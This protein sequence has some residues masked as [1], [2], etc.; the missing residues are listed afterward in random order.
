MDDEIVIEGNE[1]IISQAL[2]KNVEEFRKKLLNYEPPKVDRYGDGFLSQAYLA[3]RYS[4]TG[5]LASIRKELKL[6]S[7]TF[8]YY[9]DTNPD[10]VAAIKIGIYDSRK[11]KISEL[12]GSLFSKAIGMEIEENRVEE[13]GEVDEDGNT[14]V[15]YRKT[16]KTTKQIPPDTQAILTLLQKI[17]PSYNPK[18]VID[19]N[20]N[21]TLNVEE[22]ININVDYR[23]LSTSAI[24]E[25]LESN[26]QPVNNEINKTPDG[27]SV[28]FLGE[29]GEKALQIRNEKRTEYD[30]RK[31]AEKIEAKQR[32]EE[33]KAKQEQS[34]ITVK[35]RIMSEETKRKISEAMKKRYHKEEI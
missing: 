18:Q 6:D 35:K 29:Q 5:S 7:L 8:Q 20:F 30:N 33:E 19:V 2:P 28:R 22:D 27:K 31:K 26:K 12:E 34:G 4:E 23:M 25:L 24:R 16:T 1:G 3:A 11:E 13:S 9:M 21:K 32:A 15:A 17:D 10:F 14:K